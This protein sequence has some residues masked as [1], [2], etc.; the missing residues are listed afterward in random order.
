MSN[1]VPPKR[2]N[3]SPNQLMQRNRLYRVSA[4]KCKRGQ[5][6]H[7]YRSK[8]A[9]TPP[10]PMPNTQK[11]PSANF[12]LHILPLA[13]VQ[14]TSKGRLAK[15]TIISAKILKGDSGHGVESFPMTVK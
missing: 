2:S 15:D 13:G 1:K 12:S 6:V 3:A 11:R 8:I 14:E 5:K 4:A 7:K 10:I 9:G